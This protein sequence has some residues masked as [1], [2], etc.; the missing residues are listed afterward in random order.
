MSLSSEGSADATA[1]RSRFFF[2]FFFVD[3]TYVSQEKR[4]RFEMISYLGN[5]AF[6]FHLLIEINVKKKYF[7]CSID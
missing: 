4:C 1:L 2:F 5:V 6:F 7:Q 3:F